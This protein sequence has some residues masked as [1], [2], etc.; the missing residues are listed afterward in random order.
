VQHRVNPAR[1]W[2]VFVLLHDLV[3][4]VPV[5]GQRGLNSRN[6]EFER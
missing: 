5:A 6:R 1:Q 2:A 4:A 3:R